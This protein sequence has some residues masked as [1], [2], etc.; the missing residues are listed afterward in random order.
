MQKRFP[1]IA[2]AIVIILILGLLGGLF[3]HHE[4]ESDQIACSYCHAGLQ[5]PV[6]DLAGA[7]VVTTFAPVGFVTPRRASRI[8][9]LVQ[10]ST[11]VP[12]APPATTFA[13]MS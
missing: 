5:T 2:V 13:V 7:L 12:R 10:S 6:F 8:P 1:T 9:R 11:L 3:H 4:S